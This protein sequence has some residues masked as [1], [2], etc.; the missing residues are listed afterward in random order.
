MGVCDMSGDAEPVLQ[1]RDIID[2]LVEHV[3]AFDQAPCIELV[4]KTRPNN[5]TDHRGDAVGEGGSHHR[6]EQ[7]DKERGPIAPEES[8]Q[9]SEAGCR[10][11][12]ANI[13]V[14]QDARVFVLKKH[15]G[16][17]LEIPFSV[18]FS[19]TKVY[20]ENNSCQPICFALMGS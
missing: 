13:T 18:C 6:H 16:C 10:P 5:V 7:P 3:A 8:R 15:C 17:H 2:G 11:R 4:V 19:D 14:L 1:R 9:Y 20:H 12:K